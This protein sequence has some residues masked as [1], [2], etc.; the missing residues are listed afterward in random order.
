M[1]ILEN[2]EAKSPVYNSYSI[3]KGTNPLHQSEA[4]VELAMID[5]DH[6]NMFNNISFTGLGHII[7]T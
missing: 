1:N 5:R 3:L 4:G 2:T 7:G 6:L